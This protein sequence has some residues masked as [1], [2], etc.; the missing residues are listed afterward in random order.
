MS[1]PGRRVR[2]AARDAEILAALGRGETTIAVGERFG[3]DPSR[4][5][6]IRAEAKKRAAAKP[7]TDGDER[8]FNDATALAD[9]QAALNDEDD[10]G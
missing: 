9:E 3:I 8:E 2:N 7:V 5:S 10:D 1:A 4:V 6:Q